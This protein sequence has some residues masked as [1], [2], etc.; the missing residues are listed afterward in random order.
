MEVA[1][2]LLGPGIV[3]GRYLLHKKKLQL[4]MLKTLPTE[5]RKE[6]R[7]EKIEKGEGERDREATG[8][9]TERECASIPR[10][11]WPVFL[12]HFVFWEMRLPLGKCL[13]S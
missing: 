6:G 12:G 1:G 4:L 8:R 11:C 7:E 2:L 3:M 9:K 13:F 5:G 10:F